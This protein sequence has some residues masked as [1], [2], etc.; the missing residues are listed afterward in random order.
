MAYLKRE[1]VLNGGGI[2]E[3]GENKFTIFIPPLKGVGGCSALK[4]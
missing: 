1:K 4:M 3:C 2:K